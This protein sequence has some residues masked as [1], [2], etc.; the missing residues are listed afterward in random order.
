[1]KDGWRP[2]LRFKRVQAGQY[3]DPSLYQITPALPGELSGDFFHLVAAAMGIITETQVPTELLSRARVSSIRPRT[4]WSDTAVYGSGALAARRSRT[5]EEL[6]RTCP[7]M[8]FGV[9]PAHDNLA[10]AGLHQSFLPSVAHA[11]LPAGRESCT[12]SLWFER[13]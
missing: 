4:S 8:I 13:A 9:F 2:G 11:G 3:A 6:R 10:G 1:M 7:P 12:F 5:K